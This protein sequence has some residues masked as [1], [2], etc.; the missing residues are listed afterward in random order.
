VAKKV[1]TRAKPR[2]VA[3]RLVERAKRRPRSKLCALLFVVL[4]A[5]FGFSG[6]GLARAVLLAFAISAA[7]FLVAIAHMF[8]HSD[9]ARMR[10]RA[11]DEDQGRWG[12][13]WFGVG[14]SGVVLVALGLE[15]HANQAGGVSEV[16]L[17]ALSLLLSWL[18]MNTLFSLHYAH[19]FYGD[20]G[21]SDK[22]KTLEFPGS[23]EPDYWDFA[24]FA[25]VIGM[26]FQVSDVQIADR[27][28]RRVVLA[29]SLI[30]FFFNVV[31]IA[32]SVN[33]VAGKA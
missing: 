18:F 20:G 4:F 33:L 8:A 16:V 3:D 25:I 29:H 21:R 19:G 27:R 1:G 26:T 11:R 22:R 13:L 17:A 7:V 6:A 5:A 32:L 2:T 14:T 15:L 24:Y 9:I 23:E 10:A 30:A 12:A 28:L 31:I